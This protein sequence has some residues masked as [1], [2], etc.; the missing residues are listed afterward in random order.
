MTIRAVRT[1]ATLGVLL[2]LAGCARGNG[3]ASAPSTTPFPYRPD[4]LVLQV[5][6]T[7][8]FTTP[9]LLAGRV[10][11]LSVYG[12]GRVITEGPVPAIHPGPALPNLQVQHIDAAAV[13]TLVDRALAE[14]VGD[15]ADFGTP[16]IAD[17]VTTRFTVSTGLETLTTQVYAL[18]SAGD[19]DSRL[20]AG[21]VAARQRMQGLLDALTDLPG[22]L[23]TDAMGASG[24][25][26]P[27]AVAAVVTSYV[28]MD[29]GPA[30]P[31]AAWPGP[32]LPGEPLAAPLGVTCV[33]ATGDAATA[34]LDAAGKANALTP[35]LSADGARWSLMFRPLLP[36][37]SSCTDLKAS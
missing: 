17:D 27:T 7:G 25:Y 1:A 31:G 12:D 3:G 33:V 16:G 29:D 15:A 6:Y 20:S 32:P 14:G 5:A 22:T 8:G 2:V 30:P 23:G 11:L 24:P 37:E 34:V 21:Q 18:A 28:P 10:P 35:W 4:D 36:Q 13:Q 19:H 9:Q 26:L